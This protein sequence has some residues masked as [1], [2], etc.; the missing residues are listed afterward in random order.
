MSKNGS[1]LIKVIVLSLLLSGINVEVKSN[2]L[3]NE[4]KSFFADSY[5]QENKL[6]QLYIPKL[7]INQPVYNVDSALNDVKYHVEIMKESVLPP[8]KNSLIILAAHSGNSKIAYFN[9]L[10]ELNMNDEAIVEYL[11]KKYYYEVIDK[12]QVPKEK[13]VNL[14]LY[15]KDILYLI[16]CFK[17]TER[18]IVTLQLKVIN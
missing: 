2:N 10:N 9:N 6:L 16:T 7:K 8:S 3:Q 17:H 13:T 14:K 5:N 11:D 15:D 18:L 12:K 4:Y 1:R